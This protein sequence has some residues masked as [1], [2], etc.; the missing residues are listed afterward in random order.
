MTVRTLVK[1]CTLLCKSVSSVFKVEERF[2]Y[3]CFIWNC[4]PVG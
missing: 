1:L 4:L 2:R 3:M